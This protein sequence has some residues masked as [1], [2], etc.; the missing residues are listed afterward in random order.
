[1]SEVAVEASP[2]G[3]VVCDEAGTIQLVNRQIEA[4]FGYPATELLGR[5]IDVLVPAASRKAHATERTHFW[6]DPATRRMGAG[7]ELFGLHRD[8][9]EFPVEVG[10]TVATR[11]GRR[12]VVASVV[13]VSERLRQQSI[14]RAATNERLA[15]ERLISNIAARFVG[16]PPGQMGEVVT[17][18]LRQIVETLDLDRSALWQFTENADD[19]VYTHTWVRPGHS[20][21]PPHISAKEQFPWLLSKVRANEPVWNATVRDVPDSTDRKSLQGLDT[22]SNAV[23]PLCT[24]GGV[25]GA[26]SFGTLRAERSWGPEVRGRLQLLATVFAHALARS[27]SQQRLETAL[28]EVERL[29]ERLAQENTQLRQEVKALSGH[30]AIAAES[31]AIR[32]VLQQI[33]SVAS[34]NATVL[35]LGETGTGKEV[36]AQAIHDL[37]GRRS[38]PMVRV[39]CAAIPAALIENELFGRERGAYT[40]ALSRQIGRFEL[41]N[42][43]T[44]FL[45]EIG[46][47]PLESQVKLLRV[48]QDRVVERL[49]SVEPITVDVRLIAATNRDLAR[50]VADRTFR[51]DLYYRLNVFPITVPPLRERAEDI[52][53]LVWTF[54]EEFAKSFGKRIDSISRESL[55]ALQRYSWPGNVRELRNL[56]ERAVIVA[57]GS[58]LVVDPPRAAPSPQSPNGKLADVEAGHI[59]DVLERVGWRVRGPGGAAELLGMKPTTLDSRMAKLGI[60]RPAAR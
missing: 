15:F 40:G 26:L 8:G 57:P 31:G 41:A 14:L 28:A 39:N 1:M 58:R 18:S 49:G 32:A 16:L 22:Q 33:E 34:T 3:L 38:R 5:T 19:L 10:L 36:F 42:G 55:A 52:P 23:I 46:E 17:D 7:R 27:R 50:A 45:D 13:D 59:R 11:D 47:L 4:M 51:E 25:I 2:S 53:V 29:R 12:L 9:T 60:R 43:S 24:D 30:R 35:L 21:P 37:S 20:L 54:I 44:L 6:S 48:T 56:I